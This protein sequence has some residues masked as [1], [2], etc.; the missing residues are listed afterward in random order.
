MRIR[1]TSALTV[2]S[3]RQM[4][5]KGYQLTEGDELEADRGEGIPVD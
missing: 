4:E 5:G 1:D 2:M 3:W